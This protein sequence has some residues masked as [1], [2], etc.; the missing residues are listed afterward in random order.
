MLLLVPGCSIPSAASVV[1]EFV[2]VPKPIVGL[3]GVVGRSLKIVMCVGWG[4]EEFL[5]LQTAFG[6]SLER[7]EYC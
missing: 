4:L 2:F 3:V 1:V 5:S 6:S 7:R